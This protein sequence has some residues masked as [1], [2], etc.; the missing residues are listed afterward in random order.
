MAAKACRVACRFSAG[1]GSA[2]Q[3]ADQFLRRILQ[4]A[5]GL[6]RSVAHNDAVLGIWRVMRD[7]RQFEAAAR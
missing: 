1:E 4:Q 7:M 6:T 3:L 2:E 5:G